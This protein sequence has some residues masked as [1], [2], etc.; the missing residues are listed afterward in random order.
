MAL[1]TSMIGEFD[2]ALAFLILISATSAVTENLCEII[3]LASSIVSRSSIVETTFLAKT[4]RL[5]TGSNCS[6]ER[7]AASAKVCATN[8]RSG[9]NFSLAKRYNSP[10]TVPQDLR[11]SA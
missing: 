9:L 1:A 8:I 4:S 10:I 2:F 5:L 7:V 3:P 11:G 6:K